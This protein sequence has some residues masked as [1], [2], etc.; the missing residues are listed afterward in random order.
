MASG[1][2]Q[3]S[4]GLQIEKDTEAQLVYALDWVDWLPQGDSLAAVSW[5][6][7]ARANDPDPLVII[8]SG[9]S[10]TKTYV[11]LKE[12]QVG[13]TYVVSAL[14]NTVDGSRDRRYF[15]VKVLARSA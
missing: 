12:G 7:Q 10:G 8:S 5:S 6:I 13:K 15:R 2:I 4:Q 11:E 9:I 1:F 3:T 14:V